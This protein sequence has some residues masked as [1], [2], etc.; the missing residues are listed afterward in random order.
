LVATIAS[1]SF[2]RSLPSPSRSRSAIRTVVNT[3]P[4]TPPFAKPRS[5]LTPA[6]MPP[7]TT[8]CDV[9]SAFTKKPLNMS[10]TSFVAANCRRPVVSKPKVKPALI[11][12]PPLSVAPIGPR[13]GKY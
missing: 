13:I 9:P 6:E 12:S 4:S 3:P 5:T 10:A 2:R 11:E 8:I 1:I 7:L